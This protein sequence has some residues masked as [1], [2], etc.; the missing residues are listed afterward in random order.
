MAIAEISYSDKSDINT[1]AT[2][3]V[4]KITASNLNE[5][6]SVVNTNANLMGDLSNLTTTEKSSL[7]EAINEIDG[8]TNKYEVLYE[9]NT[10]STGTTITL[11][12]DASNFKYLAITYSRGMVQYIDVSTANN[13]NN[14]FDLSFF[15]NDGTGACGTF[16]AFYTLSNDRI[17]YQYARRFYFYTHESK[18]II[19]TTNNVAIFKVEG[20][21]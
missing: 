11:S 2:P 19:D 7:V 5:I 6:K 15:W 8:T 13:S 9:N 1:T 12:K 16:G 18:P 3:E 14:N 21:R 10:G 4:N 17:V 20:H